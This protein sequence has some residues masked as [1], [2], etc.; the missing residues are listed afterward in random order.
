MAERVSDPRT[1]LRRLA[2]LGGLIFF[3][4]VGGYMLIEG[5]TFLQALYMTV[6]TLAT[7]GYGEV[8]RLDGAGRIL[9][10]GLI[11][12]G[13]GW[14]GVTLAMF[15]QAVQEG[16][17]GERGRKRRMQKRISDLRN[18]YIV[19]GF[20]RVGRV[21]VQE[22]YEENA[23]FVVIDR[24]PGLEDTLIEY[25]FPYVIGDPANDDALKQTG[26]VRA[27]CLVSAV[28]DDADNA[29]ITLT[30]RSL[31]PNIFIVAR[32][33]H[34]T[35]QG[36]LYRAGAD[37]VVLPAVTGG[38]D[39]AHQ[40]LHRRVIDTLDFERPGLAPLFV[41]EILIEDKS[42]LADKEVGA[43]VG[44]ATALA[45]TRDTGEVVTHPTPDLRLRSGDR[46]LLLGDR[47][48]LRPLEGD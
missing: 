38:H 17:L 6:I 11:F 40:A 29:Y 45:I 39:M 15:S 43:A 25:G 19:C 16:A 42:E 5:W 2:L 41:E 12:A 28:D 32:A 8:E 31:N 26:V 33:G 30:A 24:N 34:E 4:G 37:R 7:V 35:T 22:M 13:V 44:E 27:R 48:S 14:V 20:G 46:V 9:T 18:H 36:H 3:L 23:P 21:I 1:R 10:I 47:E